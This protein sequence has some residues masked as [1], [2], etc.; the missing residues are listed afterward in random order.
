MSIYCLSAAEYRESVASIL[1]FGTGA[2]T[3]PGAF[4]LLPFYPWRRCMLALPMSTQAALRDRV[5]NVG[6]RVT[7]QRPFNEK[8]PSS[9]NL[10]SPQQQVLGKGEDRYG[11]LF[12]LDVG[13]VRYAPFRRRR[14]RHAG[15]ASQARRAGRESSDGLRGRPPVQRRGEQ[16]Q[17]LPRAQ[18]DRVPARRCEGIGFAPYMNKQSPLAHLCVSFN[19][20]RIKA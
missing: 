14:R 4:L 13:H 18:S 11:N 8:R 6:V 1:R 15:I 2:D 16:P 19:S 3:G 5:E 9:W 12:R 7:P 17:R 10:K 20:D